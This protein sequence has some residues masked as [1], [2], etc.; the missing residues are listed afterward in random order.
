MSCRAKSRYLK[1]YFILFPLYSS[2]FFANAQ[3]YQ[4]DWAINGGGSM[5]SGGW[6]FQV[7]QIFDIAIDKNNNYYFLAKIKGGTPQL[8]GQQVTIYGRH[9]ERSREVDN[10]H[11][12]LI[13]F[14][15][16]YSPFSILHSLF[17]I[18]YSLAKL[19]PK[20][21]NGPGKPTATVMQAIMVGFL[22][23]N[24]CTMW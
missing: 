3:P 17:S 6:D 16:F 23:Q 5:G 8:H 19:P 7:E 4:W 21:T 20:T 11:L 10:L 2:S 15:M 18:L 14:S 13:L 22:K 12:N 9:F 1:K 24:S